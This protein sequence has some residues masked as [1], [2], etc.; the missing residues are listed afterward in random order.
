MKKLIIVVLIT[1]FTTFC[2][3]AGDTVAPINIEQKLA[4]LQENAAQTN[5]W[6]GITLVLEN[7]RTKKD[8]RLTKKMHDVLEKEAK[9][10]LTRAVQKE[11]A[12]RDAIRKN[13]PTEQTDT[14][15]PIIT[16]IGPCDPRK[17]AKL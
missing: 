14:Y 15:T 8:S 2:A 17:R 13:W 16:A 5:I 9:Q 7:T 4:E 1:A 10:R 11:M 3:Q 12:T 6:T